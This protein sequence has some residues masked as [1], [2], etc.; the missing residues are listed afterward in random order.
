M[1]VVHVDG[2]QVSLPSDPSIFLAG[3]TPRR[4][5]ESPG[6]RPEALSLVETFEKKYAQGAELTV[7]VPE[8]QPR[9][10][11][12]GGKFDWAAQ[13]EWEWRHLNAATAIIFW[14][15]R[16][17][18]Y[19]PGFTTNVEFG[20]YVSVRRKEVVYGRPDKASKIGYLDWMYRKLAEREPCD[21]L[22]KTVQAACALA[23]LLSDR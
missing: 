2:P 1:K 12:S 15:P 9:P 6:W 11:L 4:Q 17:L 18:P 3:P 14:V 13:V 8:R 23:I 16:S 10:V 7:F 22:E 19:M 5:E 21:D 20:R